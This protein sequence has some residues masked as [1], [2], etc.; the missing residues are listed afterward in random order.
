MDLPPGYEAMML[1]TYEIIKM[2]NHNSKFIGDAF[3]NGIVVRD[4][5]N[6]FFK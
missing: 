3:R 1:T 2:K 4:D 6:L 5:Y